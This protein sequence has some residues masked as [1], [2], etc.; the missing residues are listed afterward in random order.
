MDHHHFYTKPKL[1][2]DVIKPPKSAPYDKKIHK[3]KKKNNNNTSKQQV[4]NRLTHFN[5]AMTTRKPR[6]MIQQ[7]QKQ[8]HMIW[9]DMNQGDIMRKEEERMNNNYN[10]SKHKS[11][12]GQQIFQS[13]NNNK[14]TMNNDTTVMKTASYD[15]ERHT[16]VQEQKR[17]HLKGRRKNNINN[18]INNASKGQVFDRLT[19]FNHMMATRKPRTMIQQS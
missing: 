9:R 1:V 8:H 15:L 17:C 5:H 3:K 2:D 19:H 4:F 6:T 14:K 11:L 13:H 12:T 16:Q 10:T 18:N 7:S